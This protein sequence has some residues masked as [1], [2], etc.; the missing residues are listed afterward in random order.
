MEN[1]KIKIFDFCV[2]EGVRYAVV[3]GNC[4]CCELWSPS[5]FGC[6]RKELCYEYDRSNE[7][8]ELRCAIFISP[9][10]A[11]NNIIEPN[12]LYLEHIKSNK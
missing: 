9:E 7:F 2:I 8:Q 10:K 3:Q 6:C 5:P 1:P 12:P 4:M 11:A